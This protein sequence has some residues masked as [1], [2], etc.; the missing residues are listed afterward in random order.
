MT[1]PE[2]AQAAGI[3]PPTLHRALAD[4]REEQLIEEREGDGP[5]S[6]I[7]LGRKAGVVAAVDVGRAHRRAALAD[8]HGRTIG[9]VAEQD[10]SEHPDEWGASLLPSIAELVAE[11]VKNASDEAQR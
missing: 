5:G 3:S 9:G 11:A 2:L 4:L 6:V 10:H 1:R 7:R 8:V